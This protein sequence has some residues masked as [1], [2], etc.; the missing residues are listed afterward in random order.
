[1]HLWDAAVACFR[2]CL[3]TVAIRLASCAGTMPTSA[4][5]DSKRVRER[6]QEIQAIIAAAE[7]RGTAKLCRS[8][9]EKPVRLFVDGVFDLTHY[10]H[11]NA[12]RQ[13]RALGHYLVVGVNSDD[14]VAEAKGLRPVLNDLE[15]Q[16]AVAACRFVDEIIP[17][18][19]YVMSQA[20]IE[21][22]MKTHGIDF[23]VHGDDPCIVDG[24][25]VYEDAKRLGKFLTI[26][27]TD[28]ISTT[29]IVG[30]LLMMSK[31]HHVSIISG[32]GLERDG[33]STSAEPQA[34]ASQQ[35]H[36]LV[37][38]N[39]LR[40][41]SAAL[42]G[43]TK[44]RG[45]VVYVDGAWDMFNAG[46]AEFL[47]N[48]RRFGDYLLVGVHSDA[49][50]NEHRGGQHPIMS[51]HER[52]LSVQSCRHVD[53]V[54]LNAPWFINQEMISTLSVDVVVSGTAHEDASRIANPSDPHE[55]PK[56]LGIHEVIQSEMFLSI[57]DIMARLQARADVGKRI[58]EKQRKEREWYDQKHGLTRNQNNVATRCQS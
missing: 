23:F 34:F 22:L 3:F 40:A 55:V 54:L 39:L 10:G 14:S 41:F 38:S 4:E 28:G 50:V 53:D 24:R 12:F 48:A 25:D 11:M 56:T 57:E 36:F 42:P 15:R 27:R 19:P 37:T 44:Q 16:S 26:P 7:V 52:V 49:V 51:M 18:S 35:S 45:R 21:E 5:G 33:S 20:Y 17:A 43:Q 13:A 46:H 30:R 8:M 29:D 1:M 47:K 2:G 31:D 9:S 58:Q 6:L 32:K